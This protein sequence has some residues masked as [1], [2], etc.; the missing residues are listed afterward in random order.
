[1]MRRMRR[2]HQ[3]RKAR[4]FTVV[5]WAVFFAVVGVPMAF[6]AAFANATG[7]FALLSLALPSM[8]AVLAFALLLW[9][10]RAH[11]VEVT[12]DAVIER[13]N[14]LL[15]YT[16]RRGF[17][18]IVEVGDCPPDRRGVEHGEGALLLRCRRRER[19][20]VVE[21]VNAEQFLDDLID[22]DPTFARYRGR[23]TRQTS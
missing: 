2:I 19:D 6:M 7:G 16:R 21:P 9:R 8:V 22:A 13:R 20:L 11:Q 17:D 23:V 15:V 14:P 4:G 1:M 10:W 18:E 5:Y 3:T 12:D